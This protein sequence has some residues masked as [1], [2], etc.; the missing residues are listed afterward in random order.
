MLITALLPILASASLT[1][2]IMAGEDG[3]IS[4]VLV[5]NPTGKGDDA[6]LSQPIMLC[7]TAAEL[8]AE[9]A[10]GSSGALG[11]LTGSYRSLAEQVAAETERLELAARAVQVAK[12]AAKPVSK[13]PPAT[14]SAN[15]AKGLA[16]G[17]GEN[18][19][20]GDPDNNDPSKLF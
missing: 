18:Q 2:T 9:L 14:T 5:P 4:L 1:A 10:L 19:A 20:G 7:G 8:D 11:K 15:S 12:A 17:A 3:K 6:A 16:D 13:S